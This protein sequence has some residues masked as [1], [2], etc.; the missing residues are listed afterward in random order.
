LVAYLLCITCESSCFR[1]G[2][3]NYSCQ[4]NAF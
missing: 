1:A 4:I 3:N 2:R